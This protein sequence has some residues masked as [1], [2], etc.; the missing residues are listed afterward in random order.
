M[1]NRQYLSFFFVVAFMAFPLY[2]SAAKGAATNNAK[3]CLACHADKTLTKKLMNKEI[4]SLYIDANEFGKSVHRDTGCGGC[5]PDITME[6]HPVV[7]QIKSKKEYSAN[8][9]RNCSACHTAEQMRKRLPIHSA[10]A[11]KGTC[12]E[13]HGSHHIREVAAA[14]TGVKE[15]QYCLTCHRNRITM[16]LKNGEPLSVYVDDAAIKNSVH[17]GLQ[18]T[19]CHTAFSKSS[20]PMRSFNSR[21]DYTVASSEACWKCHE[22]PYK[23][24]EMSIHLD[25]LKAGDRKAPACTDC[26]G[27]HSVASTKL[28]KNLGLTSCNKCHGDMNSSYA[29]GIHGKARMK[30]NEKAPSCSSCHNA[31]NIEAAA[32]ST[33]IKEGCL[34]CHKDAG[35]LHKKWLWNPPIALASFSAAHFDVVSCATCHSPGA[36][37][38]VYLS[39]YN[40]MTNKPLTD[41]ELIK[42][43]G[44]D[45]AGLQE[46]LDADK[47]G[48]INAKEVWNIF[49]QAIRK[50]EITIFMAKMD[51][52]NAAE[53]HNIGAKTDAV[54]DCVK[55]HHPEAELFKDVFLVLEKDDGKPIVMKADREVL[56]SVYTVLPVSKFY[57]LGSS[58]VE[59][60]DILF[61][62]ALL[63]GLAVPIGHISLRVI[64]SP[65]R[66]LRKMGKG[67]KK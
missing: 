21:R 39:L 28:D 29:A 22:E 42:I 43:F 10:L 57:A 25:K 34:K 27:D 48:V 13:C 37:R 15:N 36:A 19:E 18:C 50:G 58:S 59:I 66:A 8:L 3:F 53:A 7:K 63:G 65:I 26:H 62:V 44:T 55:C 35:K 23:K 67:G 17:S 33:Q 16:S 47:N 5:H 49:E 56:N 20:H 24:Y 60:L 12:V 2:A 31:H 45:S 11:A 64:T 1:S 30:G 41:E 32:G 40:R 14:K 52:S 38:G 4:L 9:S 46:K 6:N 61:I 51:V 54:K